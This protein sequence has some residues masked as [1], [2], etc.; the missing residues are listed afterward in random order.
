MQISIAELT[1]NPTAIKQLINHHNDVQ[2]KLSTAHEHLARVESE[3][4]YLKTSPFLAVFALGGNVIGGTV[5]AIGVNIVTGSPS[6]HLGWVLVYIGCASVGLSG[7]M[8]ILYPF[9][10][11]WFNPRNPSSTRP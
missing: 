11:R 10:R 3:V 1:N 9:A 2:R 7:L 4:E 5:S 6:N 8:S